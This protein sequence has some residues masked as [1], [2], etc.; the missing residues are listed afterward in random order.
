MDNKFH[1]FGPL[2]NKSRNTLVLLG[3]HKKTASRL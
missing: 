3:L 2:C 1:A